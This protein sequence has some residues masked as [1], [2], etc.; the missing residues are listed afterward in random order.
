MTKKY[1]WT[2]QHIFRPSVHHRPPFPMTTRERL[3][4]IRKRCRKTEIPSVRVWAVDEKTQDFCDFCLNLEDGE[5]FADDVFGC[6]YAHDYHAFRCRVEAK[7][8]FHRMSRKERLYERR[9]R[10]IGRGILLRHTYERTKHPVMFRT[11]SYAIYLGSRARYLACRARLLSRA[12]N[13]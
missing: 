11:L 2:W 13:R 1:P 9:K 4:E 7:A 5:C 12:K 6:P 10:K 8:R 3:Y